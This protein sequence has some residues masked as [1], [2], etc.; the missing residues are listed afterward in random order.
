[1]TRQYKS[2]FE[3]LVAKLSDLERE[4]EENKATIDRLDEELAALEERHKKEEEDKNTEI[5]GHKTQ[6]EQMSAEFAAMLKSTLEKMND[7]IR[8]ANKQWE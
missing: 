7:R 3:E 4:K 2:R 6:I 1:M 5:K 8:E